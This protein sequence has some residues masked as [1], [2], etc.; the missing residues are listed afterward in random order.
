MKTVNRIKRVQDAWSMMHRLKKTLNLGACLLIL[1]ALASC[2][3]DLEVRNAISDFDEGNIHLSISIPDAEVVH[4]R[5]QTNDEKTINNTSCSHYALVYTTATGDKPGTLV[6]RQKLTNLA[7]NV[8]QTIELPK[9]SATNVKIVVVANL[10]SAQASQVEALSIDSNYASLLNILTTALSSEPTAPFVMS[11]VASY[12]EPNKYSAELHRSVAKISIEASSSVSNFTLTGYEMYN[13]PSQGYIAAHAA[14]VTGNTDKMYQTGTNKYTVT[15]Q[16]DS[17]FQNYTYPVGSAGKT[18]DNPTGAYFIVKGEYNGEECYYRVDLRKE[19]KSD[20]YSIEPNHWYQVEI[21]SVSQKGYPSA[22]EAAKRYMGQEDMGGIIEIAIHDHI[23]EVLSMVTDG[24]R[25]LGV[26]DRIEME[27]GKTKT[28]TIKTYGG[29]TSNPTIK[30]KTGQSDW[31]E[32]GEVKESDYS[33]TSGTDDGD[34]DSTGKLFESILMFK[35]GT[36]YSDKESIL[37]VSW[38]GLEIEV[39]VFYNAVFQPEKACKVTLK[40]LENGTSN[41]GVQTYC[42]WDFLA[43]IGSSTN[44]N[45]TEYSVTQTPG[46]TG[47]SRLLGVSPDDLA[48][49]KIRNEGFHFPMPYGYTSTTPWEYEYTINFNPLTSNSVDIE[50]ITATFSG[51][52][53]INSGNFQFTFDYSKGGVLKMIDNK[54]SY[55]YATGKVE[56]KITFKEISGV[57]PDPISIEMDIYHTG[58][59]H[60]DD[61]SSTTADKGYYYYE[62]VP[63]GDYHWL[64][65]NIGAKSNKM[66]VDNGG[67]DNYVG[68][69]N[70]KGRFY[71]VATPGSNYGNPTMK[72]GSS[73][74]TICPPGYHVPNQTEWDNLRLSPNFK[75]EN[76]TEGSENYISNF[77]ESSN[78]KVGKIYFQKSR[79]Y[80]QDNSYAT[81]YVTNNPNVGDNGAGYYWSRNVS[82]GLEKKE[83]G[84]WLKALYINGNSNTFIN[85]SIKNNKMNLRCSAGV[86]PPAESKNS[87]DFNVKGAT[88]VFLYYV[89]NGVK[90]GIFS[91]PGKSIGN[92]STVDKLI[93]ST[94]DSGYNSSY[95]H[96]STTSAYS[97]DDLYVFFAYVTD[98]GKITIISKNNATTLKDALGWPVK[99]GYNYFFNKNNSFAPV[100][101]GS[102]NE[103]PWQDGNAVGGGNDD[104]N[105]NYFLSTDGWT[106]TVQWPQFWN[107]TNV[108]QIH[109][110]HKNG[111]P[112]LGDFPGGKNDTHSFN[113]GGEYTKTFTLKQDCNSFGVKFSNIEKDPWVETSDFEIKSTGNASGITVTKDDAKKNYYVTIKW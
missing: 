94:S 68:E 17:R 1:G 33:E 36:F 9:S 51:D 111:E 101:G 6:H 56:F 105:N 7:E 32:F 99:V 96:F 65:R 54:T 107:K 109:C 80:N 5:A 37:V 84:Q 97:E 27:T 93:Y 47:V 113:N 25:E 72:D 18:V 83:I 23:A 38:D 58:F 45:S 26:T 79:Y 43:G 11:G 66:Y 88:H 92:Q 30:F 15:T 12:S 98:A 102:N 86:N 19:D 82:S 52:D 22:A 53:F 20:Y 31:L 89:E 34:P 13:A 2:S 104:S 59:F 110:W 71:T 39:K 3:D 61:S 46:A 16:T 112:I 95:L 60:F 24:K 40:I 49:G 108:Y 14:S 100:P 64:D 81:T 106:V 48:D 10:P 76:I 21:L 77:Y 87:I 73:N 42:Y 85:G 28:L 103:F 67:T 44:K 70:A 55:T 41:F 74:N 63:L 35:P 50:N 75:S 90:S 29:S 69:L 4:T 91:F 57:R 8:V 78:L 62:V